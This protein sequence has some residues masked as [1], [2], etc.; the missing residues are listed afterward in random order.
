MPVIGPSIWGYKDIVR[1]RSRGADAISFGA[2]HLRFPFD[3]SCQTL[4]AKWDRRERNK[5]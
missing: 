4:Y 1:V 5:K 2:V 3:R